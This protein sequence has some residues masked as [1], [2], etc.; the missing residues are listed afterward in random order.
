MVSVALTL[1]FA[2][3]FI[4][5]AGSNKVLV[6]KPT[7]LL[8]CCAFDG[9]FIKGATDWPNYM[10]LLLE[11]YRSWLPFVYQFLPFHLI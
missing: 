2:G 4:L 6:S 3:A 10:D 8:V 1:K 7:C 5:C 11:L 9:D